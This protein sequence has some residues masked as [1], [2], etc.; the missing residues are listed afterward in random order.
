MKISKVVLTWSLSVVL[1]AAVTLV[2]NNDGGIARAA[3]NPAAAKACI[4]ACNQQWSQCEQGCSGDFNCSVGCDTV[5]GNC[6][7]YCQTL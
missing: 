5:K 3:G 7:S 2:L 1:S 6:I 4:N